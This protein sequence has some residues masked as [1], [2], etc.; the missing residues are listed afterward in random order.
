MRGVVRKAVWEEGNENP[1]S[2]AGDDNRPVL[3]TSF[4]NLLICRY[5]DKDIKT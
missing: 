4:P 2:N 1:T 5:L 3:I